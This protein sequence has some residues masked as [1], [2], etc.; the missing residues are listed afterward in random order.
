MPVSKDWYKPQSVAQKLSISWRNYGA[1]CLSGE[2]WRWA[3]G[4]GAVGKG[5]WGGSKDETVAEVGL[6]WLWGWWQYWRW[7]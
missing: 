1:L 5:V 2:R 3:E 6:T 4:E 7:Q